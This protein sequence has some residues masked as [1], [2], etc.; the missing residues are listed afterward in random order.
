[1]H[2]HRPT[3]PR[4]RLHDLPRNVRGPLMAIAAGMLAVFALVA[5]WHNSGTNRA[6]RELR[7][8]TEE[9]A[10][11]RRGVEEARELLEQRVAE[12]R[13]AEAGAAA[14]AARLDVERVR[15]ADGRTTTAVGGEVDPLVGDVET[16]AAET[17][18]RSEGVVPR[19][20]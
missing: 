13:A 14:R 11:R 9:V 8:A 6:A 18:R 16:R 19:R 10:E 20:P 2:D 7:H 3:T 1:M 17:I 15:A 5:A 4:W 12:L